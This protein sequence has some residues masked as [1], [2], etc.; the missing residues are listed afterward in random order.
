MSV[1]ANIHTAEQLAQAGELGRCELVR[2]RLM[3]MSP[4]GFR[5][6]Q[7]TAQL[8]GMLWQIVR[9]GKLGVITAAET[10]YLLQRDPDTVRAP[11]I[12]FVRAER[13]STTP[14]RG[15]FRGAPDL[16][17]EV[18]SPN[19]SASQMLA[20]VEE[21]LA[22]GAREVW[23]V[24]GDRETITRFTRQG[25]ETTSRVFGVD[26]SIDSSLFPQMSIPLRDVFA[27]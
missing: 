12:G 13:A 19:D 17:V 27:V 25:D 18:L 11:D 8:S 6:G 26:E 24:D 7:I 2:G 14:E 10:G 4:A 22:S 9:D 23:M 16:A 21:W 1:A 5:H 15:Y 3:M 20:K